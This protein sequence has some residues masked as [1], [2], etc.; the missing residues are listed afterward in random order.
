MCPRITELNFNFEW[1]DK[2]LY[3]SFIN[4]CMI[5][6]SY[7]ELTSL[8]FKL[9]FKDKEIS[10]YIYDILKQTYDGQEISF[11]FKCD[12]IC[13]NDNINTKGLNIQDII[14]DIQCEMDSPE[15]YIGEYSFQHQFQ[16]TQK[17]DKAQQF[18]FILLLQNNRFIDCF[19]FSYITFI[20]L[21]ILIFFFF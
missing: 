5:A 13:L 4:I 19:L 2:S 12:Q 9:K 16:L 15:E 18:S 6:K 20:C 21:I 11:K 10:K 8:E 17:I 1:L 7:K 3:Q 14:Y